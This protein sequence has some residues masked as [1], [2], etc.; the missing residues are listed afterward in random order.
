VGRSA[1]GSALTVRFP[2]GAGAYD[3]PD[4]HT[5]ISDAPDQFS[6]AVGDLDQIPDANG[7]NHDEVVVAYATGTGPTYS[8]QLKVLNY[9]KT[10]TNGSD[11]LYVTGAVAS[12]QLFLTNS[13]GSNAALTG[14][15]F[16]V[17]IGDFDG[18]GQNEIALATVNDGVDR[19]GVIALSIFRYRHALLTDTPSL[20]EVTHTLFGPLLSDIRIK[21]QNF[22]PA[23][24]LAA[25]NFT[26][27]NRAKLVVAL[28]NQ[29]PVCNCVEEDG[30][31]QT[32]DVLQAIDVDATLKPTLKG[33]TI[34]NFARYA[35]Y[36]KGPLT[37]VQVIA[38]PR[39]VQIRSRQR[40]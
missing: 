17:A 5:P 18:D 3:L 25:G 15:R 40:I 13:P 7:L 38:A 4:L 37:A 32:D 10:N 1:D 23:I 12:N 27:K 9:T 24:S 35:P 8:I 20:V 28:K 16:A 26:G 36:Q 39:S 6:V 19:P 11:P 31:W 2:F 14:E 22:L 34:Q 30:I 33:R 21:P 29:Q